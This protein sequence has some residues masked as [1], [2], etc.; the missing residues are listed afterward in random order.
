LRFKI[1]WHN[2]ANLANKNTNGNVNL[3]NKNSKNSSGDNN[4]RNGRSNNQNRNNLNKNH[5]KNTNDTNANGKQNLSQNDQV[6]EPDPSNLTGNLFSDGSEEGTVTPSEQNLGAE[7]KSGEQDEQTQNLIPQPQTAN[8][9]APSAQANSDSLRDETASL[10][11]N[12]NAANLTQNSQMQAGLNQPTE[13][14]FAPD[15][16]S[17][18][19]DTHDFHEAYSLKFKT[20]DGIAAGA[21][22]A[23]LDAELRQLESQNAAK[24]EQKPIATAKFNQNHASQTATFGEQPFDPDDVSE[25]F[26]EAAEYDDDLFEQDASEPA[27]ADVRQNLD[28][29]NLGGE[30]FQN[31]V[32]F[33]DSSLNEANLNAQNPAPNLAAKT[34]TDHKAAKNQAVL[35]E[36]KRL[37]G[38][39]EILEI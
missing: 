7:F 35:K 38:E 9:S 28:T 26:G 14:K 11:L 13:P 39:P 1:F 6:Q 10:N 15:F 19:N 30:E 21:D 25:I 4:N 17:M 12:E 33:D 5:Q 2:D 37:F 20:D 34:Q 22:L 16:E 24:T 18:R 23:F 3:S 36:A 29:A 27:S 31:E 32:N 8:D